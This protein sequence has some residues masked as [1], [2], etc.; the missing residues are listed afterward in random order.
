M[1]SQAI[2]AFR[3]LSHLSAPNSL[4]TT[5]L[6]RSVANRQALAASFSSDAGNGSDGGAGDDAAGTSSIPTAKSIHIGSEV[7]RAE[8]TDRKDPD[9]VISAVLAEWAAGRAPTP[10]SSLKVNDHSRGERA[11]RRKRQERIAKIKDTIARPPL[12]SM[13]AKPEETDPVDGSN[14]TTHQEAMAEEQVRR[15]QA[16]E[17]ILAS[18]EGS[19]ATEGARGDAKPGFRLGAWSAVLGNTNAAKIDGRILNSKDMD[20]WQQQVEA[21]T[22]TGPDAMNQASSAQARARPSELNPWEDEYN[23]PPVWGTSKEWASDADKETQSEKEPFVWNS[24][25]GKESSHRQSLTSGLSESIASWNP[26]KSWAP[27][28]LGGDSDQ[29][30]LFIEGHGRAGKPDPPPE[31]SAQDVHD[32]RDEICDLI[33]DGQVREA[34]QLLK[35]LHH[36]QR[37]NVATY[38]AVMQGAVREDDMGTAERVAR[39]MTSSRYLA[40]S[41]QYA[42]AVADSMLAVLDTPHKNPHHNSLVTDRD[43]FTPVLGLY[44]IIVPHVKSSKEMEKVHTLLQNAGRLFNTWGN[45]TMTER[46]KTLA[47]GRSIR[48]ALACK[49]PDIAHKFLDQHLKFVGALPDPDEY[50]AIIEGYLDRGMMSRAYELRVDFGRAFSN[51]LEPPLLR[52]LDTETRAVDDAVEKYRES[53]DQMMS[54]G[55]S[56]NIGSVHAILVAWF[57]AVHAGVAME[58]MRIRDGVKGADREAYGHYFNLLSPDKLAVIAL[59][60]TLGLLLNGPASGVPF[61]RVAVQIGRSVQTE[62]NLARMKN[63][64]TL[65]NAKVITRRTVSRH[66]RRALRDAEWPTAAHAKVGSAL[67]DV[68]MKTA[69]VPSEHNK[70]KEDHRF[71]NYPHLDPEL[72]KDEVSYSPKPVSSHEAN[73]A[74]AKADAEKHSSR[75]AFRHVM[76]ITRLRQQGFLQADQAVFRSIGEGEDL[77]AIVTPRFRPMLVRPREWVRSNQGGYLSLKSYIMRTRGSKEQ[78]M[79]LRE[80]FG[81]MQEVCDAL[82]VLGRTPW[83]IN[84]DILRVVEEVWKSGGGVAEIPV[85]ENLPIPDRPDD[86]ESDHSVRRQY[87][88][89]LTKVAQTNRNRHSL[90]CSFKL[91]LQVARDFAGETIYFPHNLDFRGRA[92]PIPPHL[93]HVGSDFCRGLLLFDEGRPLGPNGLNWVKIHLANLI[94]KDKLDFDGR[95]EYIND[96]MDIVMA[97]ADR[98]LSEPGRQLWVE[99]DE[100]WQALAT[101]IDLT[102]AVRSGDPENYVSRLPVHQDGSCNGLQHYAALG[103]DRVGAMSVDLIPADKPQDVYSNVA[104]MLKARVATMAQEGHEMAKKVH[105]AGWIDRKLIKQ[106]V[107]TSVYGVT[108]IGAKEQIS[109]RLRERDVDDDDVHPVAMFLAAETMATMGN[110]FTG[111]REIMTWLASCAR[112]VAHRDRPVS[113]VTPLGLPVVQPYRRLNRSHQ[114]KTLVQAITVFDKNENLPVSAQR[115]Q[116]AFPPN[117]VHS[118]DSSHMMLTALSCA[119]NG[120][121]FASV[122]DSYWTHAGSIE[123]MNKVIRD[124]FVNLYERPLLEDLLR[125]LQ[126]TFPTAEFPP[127]PP[128]GD[129]DLNEVKNSLYFFD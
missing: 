92:Y 7:R 42:N 69:A 17:A 122:H 68:V 93:N 119:K 123:I 39:L 103:R 96:H 100:P 5:W 88:K 124:E 107:M 9:A 23:N 38:S 18:V 57:K 53:M 117:Y 67:L 64:R 26:F 22:S 98:P 99:A 4:R 12:G 75:P 110:L 6:R 47:T 24:N 48:D 76:I 115:Q 11:V 74:L 27:Q 120:L 72:L 89:N 102:R 82:D 91:Q 34:F 51:S 1:A 106:T 60:E 84:E 118:L 80:G 90:R 126:E 78:N 71:R 46:D 44:D 101:C 77:R 66:A 19:E 125:Q 121:T 2:G 129:L 83:R 33:D 45:E 87:W 49:R 3:R 59:H 20:M 97:A 65:P 41:W 86:M 50:L 28:T 8:R 36:A 29:P 21:S 73:Q 55:L 61:A 128:R 58:Q 63:D 35:T 85:T 54:T 113:W 79:A 127:I 70:E 43:P 25:A 112:V 105:E 16:E 37:C 111:A 14:S 108:F 114:I 104:D 56:A 13:Q 95:I 81:R 10:G 31:L 94:G 62:V 116:S 30:G 32:M 109:N 15:S 40:R 52:Q